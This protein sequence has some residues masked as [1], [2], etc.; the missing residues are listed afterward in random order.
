MA[1][2]LPI[3]RSRYQ[4]ILVGSL[5]LEFE[6]LTKKGWSRIGLWYLVY[7]TVVGTS[8]INNENNRNEK[9][10]SI[11]FLVK[12]IWIYE[13]KMTIKFR[14]FFRKNDYFLIKLHSIK[15]YLRYFPIFPVTL[16]IG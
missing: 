12:Y 3:N 1:V 5:V 2:Q 14:Y 13:L 9:K 4:C 8:N 10:K 15:V 16:K 11:P 6:A 7:S